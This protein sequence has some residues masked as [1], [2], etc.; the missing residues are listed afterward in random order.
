MIVP[1]AGVE[2]VP[3]FQSDSAID[4][5]GTFQTSSCL[6]NGK[7]GLSPDLNTFRFYQGISPTPT[8]FYGEAVCVHA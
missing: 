6:T 7:P 5:R 8:E 3:F 4:M 2:P 1:I